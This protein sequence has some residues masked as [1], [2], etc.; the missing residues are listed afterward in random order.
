MLWASRVDVG[1]ERLRLGLAALRD[2][3]LRDE[4]EELRLQAA[5]LDDGE[6]APRLRLCRD[7][8]ARK[9]LE[10]GADGRQPAS[11]MRRPSSS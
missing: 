5:A 6:P 8:V 4:R 7:R 10:L 9:Q 2:Q 11:G 3:R 1:E